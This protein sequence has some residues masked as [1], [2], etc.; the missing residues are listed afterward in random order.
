VVVTG[1][2]GSIRGGDRNVSFGS[3]KEVKNMKK[4]GN[5]ITRAKNVR[6]M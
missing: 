6:T 4:N 2:R 5:S 3:L 1:F